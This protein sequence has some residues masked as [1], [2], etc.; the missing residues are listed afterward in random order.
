[1]P[2]ISSYVS[3]VQVH[4]T[5]KESNKQ[6]K[7]LTDTAKKLEEELKSLQAQYESLS[8]A[9]KAGTKGKDLQVQMKQTE[10]QLKT[11]NRLIKQS[12]ENLNRLQESLTNMTGMS[13]RDLTTALSQA[14]NEMRKF[15][16]STMTDEDMES[17]RRL[18]NHISQLEVRIKELKAGFADAWKQSSNYTKGSLDEN[19]RLKR[20]LTEQRDVLSKNS[21]EWTKITQRI[22]AITFENFKKA[23]GD[24]LLKD[25]S[26]A[27]DKQL[28]DMQRFLQGMVDAGNLEAKVLDKVKASLQ[29]VNETIQQRA[30]TSLSERAGGIMQK[31]EQ[32]T[33]ARQALSAAGVPPTTGL[34]S[35]Q[36]QESIKLL[37]QYRETLATTDTSGLM[38]V[39][40]TIRKMSADLQQA[41]ERILEAKGHINSIVS[42]GSGFANSVKD[43]ERLKTGLTEYRKTIDATT[44]EGV[45]EIARVEEEFQRLTVMEKTASLTAEHYREIVGDPRSWSSVKELE[46]AYERL[47]F[48]VQKSGVSAE[49]FARKSEVMQLIKNR[50]NELKAGFQSVWQTSENA[51]N[52]SVATNLRVIEVLKQEQQTLAKTQ[53]QWAIYE[54]RINSVKFSNWM[55]TGGGNV[56]ADIGNATDKQLS[57]AQRFLQ[58]MVD[59]GNMEEQVLERVKNQLEAINDTIQHRAQTSL[60]DKAQQAMNYTSGSQSTAKIQENIKLLQQYRENLETTNEGGLSRVDETI[61]KMSA[62][63]QQ[64]NDRV[65]E[66]KNYLTNVNSGN[67]FK[68][69][70]TDLD[71]LR[72]GLRA[73]KSTLDVTSKDGQEKIIAVER[74]L[75]RLDMLQ[76]TATLTAERFDE[77]LKNPKGVKNIDELKMAYKRLKFEINN[78]N[79]T[80]DEYVAK[81]AQMKAIDKQMKELTETWTHHQSGIRGAINRLKSYIAVYLG[82]NA[83]MNEVRKQFGHIMELS[84][85]MTN[86]QKVTNMTTE[87]V[88][89]LSKSLQDLDTRTPTHDLMEFATQAGKLGI[90]TEHGLEGMK[91]FVEMG[92]RINATLG[93]DIGGA[94]AIAGLA[95]VNDVL[96]ETKKHG[97][98]VGEALDAAGSSI[99]NLGNNTAASYQG[100]MEYV[101]RLGAVGATARMTM[102]Q[103]IAL[104]GRLDAVGISAEQGSTALIHL[105]RGVMNH[106]FEMAKAAQ[107]APTYLQ[108]LIDEGKSYEALVAVLEKI[109]DAEDRAGKVQEVMNA[110]GT[111]RMKQSAGLAM[112]LSSLATNTAALG[113]ALQYA[114]EGYESATVGMGNVSVMSRE[115]S[116]VQEN[117]A[118]SLQRLRNAFNE[119]FTNSYI[120]DIFNG[121]IKGLGSFL[122][123][124]QKGSQSIV[125][126]QSTIK[127]LI[128]T[129]ISLQLNIGTKFRQALEHGSRALKQF[130]QRLVAAQGAAQTFK[131]AIEGLKSAL[132]TFI[133]FAVLDGIIKLIQYIRR[134]VEATKEFNEA[135]ATAAKE[136]DEMIAKSRQL[137]DRISQLTKNNEQNVDSH[138][139]LKKTINDL[140]GVMQSYLG[141]QLSE[142]NL[143][144]NQTQARDLLNSKIRETIVLKKQEAA[145]KLL[146][147][148]YGTTRENRWTGVRDKL[149]EEVGDRNTSVIESALRRTMQRLVDALP[150]S[151]LKNS[152]DNWG[153][154][155]MR[156]GNMM[157]YLITQS[158]LKLNKTAKDAI[159]D[160]FDDIKKLWNDLVKERGERVRLAEST[161]AQMDEAVTRSYQ[162]TLKM[163]NSTLKEIQ[164]LQKQFNGSTDKKERQQLAQR[165]V[166]LST[167]YQN[168]AHQAGPRMSSQVLQR[169]ENNNRYLQGQVRNQWEDIAHPNVWGKNGTTLDKMDT[170]TLKNYADYLDSVVENGLK[171]GQQFSKIY[172]DL[173]KKGVLDDSMSMEDAQRSVKEEYDKVKAELDR[174]H[175]T[176]QGNYKSDKNSDRDKDKWKREAKDERDATLAQLDAYY[177]EREALIK[178]RLAEESITEEEAERRN[179]ENELVW[180]ADRMK[181]RKQWTK[182]LNATE[183]KQFVEHWNNELKLRKANWSLIQKFMYDVRSEYDGA[184][185]KMQEDAT[186]IQEIIHKHKDAIEKILLEGDFTG[187]V[188]DE[189][190][191]SMDTIGFIF[192]MNEEAEERT[193]ALAEKRLAQLQAW[194]RDAYSL[195]VEQLKEAMRKEDNIYHVWFEGLGDNADAELTAFLQKL[196]QYSDD[197]IDAERK[198]AKEYTR[199]A[200]KIWTGRREEGLGGRTQSELAE[201]RERRSQSGQTAASYA[202]SWGFGGELVSANAEIDVIYAQME[203]KKA[204]I[205]LLQQETDKHIENMKAQ[206]AETTA[207]LAAKELDYAR[208]SSSMSDEER[209]AAENEI[210]SLEA[211][212]ASL[213]M[214]V[215]ELQEE[216]NI[217]LSD[218]YTAMTD[219]QEKYMQKMVERAARDFDTLQ[220]YSNEMSSFAQSFGEGVF[221]SKEDRQNAAKQLLTDV[222]TTT[223]NLIQQYLIQVSTKRT[224]DQMEVQLE[225]QKQA[226]IQALRQQSLA[227]YGAKKIAELGVEGSTSVAE[228]AVGSAKGTAKEVAKKGWLGLAIGAA[229][230]LALSSLLGLA[231]GAINKS[232]SEVAAATGASSGQLKAGFLTYAEGRYPVL[233][234][235]G[236]T[237]QAKRED[238]LQTKIYRGGAHYGIF[239]EKMPE[240]VIDGPTTQKLVLNY[241]EIWDNIQVLSKTGVIP[242]YSKRRKQGGVDTYADGNLDEIGTTTDAGAAVDDGGDSME[243]MQ[244]LIAANTAMLKALHAQLEAG[245]DAYVDMYGDGG[246]RKRLQRAD[247][248]MNRRG[249]G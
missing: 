180:L 216:Q 187:K 165:L 173:V 130:W 133:V 15:G 214:S 19:E 195:T 217:A 192:G 38:R 221:G 71:S 241:P 12:R 54:K 203:A 111:G 109:E 128:L 213:Q 69:T 131:V 30:Q 199:V 177:Q 208:R 100:I 206:E 11:Q 8:E 144:K 70:L 64:A 14:R 185:R 134:G 43:I 76:E 52:N 60:E 94:E 79:L 230:S 4:V 232:K 122:S 17:F 53:S 188:R 85:Q 92:E 235:D 154:Q 226:Q 209:K 234:A 58:G 51:S 222:L 171:V 191:R 117:A 119:L 5:T 118:G 114:S 39:D 129:L 145:E 29:S 74:E 166:E 146:E 155:N 158:G 161:G 159:Y 91:G 31:Y 164:S 139:E 82:F 126:W 73:Y 150:N 196:Q 160:N 186:K 215:R 247:K 7:L 148:K 167:D 115:F 75:Q 48:E 83:I 90:Y 23:G 86:V 56:L 225:A 205:A 229:I 33:A 140:N 240:A 156:Q 95:K 44:D 228:I 63:L 113:D 212:R 26:A 67:G 245:I 183:S 116:K 123:W 101:R 127:A 45:K 103:L 243:G 218:S 152:Q 112:T 246:I 135:I 138:R 59:A 176:I 224:V 182:Q 147:E 172:A 137:S 46:Q 55:K 72:N 197:I 47:S 49:E 207:R 34:N 124:M 80:Q 157:E 236:E 105:I 1:M 107:L 249:R 149:T 189:F 238:K 108:S 104:G 87:E 21:K 178:Q 174:R 25:L 125:S 96:G 81:A 65:L 244:S 219:L 36:L 42:G 9:E 162:D 190:R 132:K 151:E 32:A 242:N 57:D 121:I 179:N 168:L 41:N 22:N 237:Y 13:V 35:A 141:F 3:N 198:A 97:D 175:D 24:T 93:E 193:K 204:Y 78:T 89:R 110:V 200:D 194:A 88:R 210:Q 28:S 62:D 153:V 6:I 233:G 102:P 169:V 223:K 220:E 136:E 239:S 202:S 163:L 184:T 142:T 98:D 120:Y 20:V 40:E 2:G 201:D 84:D 61:R 170:E 248:F 143:L 227:D 211:R 37:Q 10:E 27:T 181:L 231:L 18:A 68:G 50:L 77:I 66:A 99:L 16:K 106:T